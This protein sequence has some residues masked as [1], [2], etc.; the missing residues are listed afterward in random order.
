M[1]GR[2][3]S[4][5]K[6]VSRDLSGTIDAAAV[7]TT[8][9]TPAANATPDA[10]S[11]GLA[12]TMN[13]KTPG[14]LAEVI[15][16]LIV[17]KFS[18]TLT[19]DTLEKQMTSYLTEL[20]V[21]NDDMLAFMSDES[22]P[23]PKSMN[24]DLKMLT[25]PVL[26]MLHTIA[27]MTVI[28][29]QSSLYLTPST[30]YDVL[31]TFAARSPH[32]AINDA[33][34]SGGGKS[35]SSSSTEVKVP[36]FSVPKFEGDTLGGDK[37]IDKVSTKF[38]SNGQSLYLESVQHCTEN[39]SWSSAF[40]SR[41]RESL[42]DSAILGF[43]SSELDKE[44]NSAKVWARISS[45][46]N[47]SDLS[48]AREMHNWTEFFALKCE[49]KESFLAFYSQAKKLLHKLTVGKSVA[50]TDDVF[51]KA[52]MAKVIEAP[53]LQTEAKQ[54]LMEGSGTYA[55]ILENI[56]KDFRALET[57]EQMRD[58]NTT[59]D[60]RLRRAGTTSAPIPK[61][62]KFEPSKGPSL[63]RCP[64]NTGNLIPHSYYLQFK[65]WYDVSRIPEKDRTEENKSF[66]TGFKWKHTSPKTKAAW[67]PRN[68][69]RQH[70]G[71]GGGRDNRSSR[72]SRHDS[73]HRRRSPSSSPDRSDSDRSRHRRSRRS[74]KRNRSPQSRSRSRSP[75][76]QSAA[77]RSQMFRG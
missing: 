50:V 77:R 37:F 40:A 5:G 76:K 60:T 41:L 33:C 49:N 63:A 18:Y 56:Y 20:G 72:R 34:G 71:R 46:L 17:T 7:Q 19:D 29:R 47:S 21:E 1:M 48:M 28:V 14:E 27:G 55:E 59:P 32:P 3:K 67:V 36:N 69:D 61:K 10:A 58:G 51:L 54:F 35:G 52:F 15:V 75:P 39:T 24:L 65:E 42:A 68:N 57:G 64:P 11:F 53:E 23:S 66:L 8:L 44:H 6:S 74:G 70:G 38:R 45:H 73:H 16:S 13:C 12:D 62:V 22:F 9:T 31:R 26:R 25:I 30:T 4:S 43:L 2:S